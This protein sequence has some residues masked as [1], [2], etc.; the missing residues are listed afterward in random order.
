MAQ[1]YR[2]DESKITGPKISGPRL[3][4]VVSHM[5]PT[6]MGGLKVSLIKMDSDKFGEKT[7]ERFVRYCPPFFGATNFAFSGANTGNDAAYQ[8][9]QKSYGMSFVP[10]DVGV[11]VLCIFLEETGEGFWIGCVPD[12]YMNQMVPAI[13]ANA[14][15]DQGPSDSKLYEK[16]WPLPTAEYNKKANTQATNNDIDKVKRPV[17]PFAGVLQ[18][19]GLIKDYFRGTTTSSMRRN[20]ISNVYGI[21]TPGPLDKRPNAKKARLGDKNNLTEPVFVSRIGGTQLVMDD[22]DDRF[23][24]KTA[25]GEGP[26]TYIPAAQGGGDVRVPSNEY[27]RVRTRTGHQILLHNSEDLIYIG[28][29]SGGSWIEMSSNGKIDIYAADSVS[30]HTEQDFNFR[31]DRDINFEAGRNMNIKTMEGLKIEVDKS[32]NLIVTEDQKIWIKG[33]Q[34]TTVDGALKTAVKNYNLSASDAMKISSTNDANFS[35][36]SGNVNLQAA[37]N[38]NITS[39]GNHIEF[40]KKVY[41]NSIKPTPASAADTS[42]MEKPTPTELGEV[43][44]TNGRQ[45]FKATQYQNTTGLKTTLKRVPMHEPWGGHENTDPAK[46]DS[47]VLDREAKDGGTNI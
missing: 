39:A 33:N 37:T 29:G 11:T 13:G 20:A 35:S 24:R 28:H 9:T 36:T 14:N 6:F 2:I 18:N 22:G 38:T 4:R 10:P 31:A 7:Q 17:H 12:R 27:F 3:A 30:I 45:D 16:D 1:E 42:G 47:K 46:Y 5:D 8:D 25:A 43:P 19:Q 21:S 34:E 23:I 40:A 26:P 15:T 44:Q 41:M 32:M